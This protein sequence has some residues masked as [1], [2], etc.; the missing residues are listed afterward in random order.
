MK[1][2]INLLF[3][4]IA[5]IKTNQQSVCSRAQLI[6]VQIQGLIEEFLYGKP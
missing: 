2:S 1:N 4:V 3:P 5:E 6:A